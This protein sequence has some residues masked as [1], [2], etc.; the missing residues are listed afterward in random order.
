MMTFGFLFWLF[1]IGIIIACL[2]DLKR[3]EVDN[4]LNL[5]LIMA[6]FS[7]IFFK[8]IFEKDSTIVFQAGLALVILFAIMNLF[9]YGRIFAGGDAKLLFAMTAFFIGTRFMDTLVNIG[10]F[11]LFLMVAGSMY[12]LTYSV[13]LYVKNFKKVNKKIR[14][15]FSA[16]WIRYLILA[17]TVLLV[18]SYV[19]WI[20]LFLAI[21][22]LVLP[23]LYVFAK[24]LE[25]VAMTRTIS[26]ENLRE[27]DWLAKDIKI[28]R[29]VIKANWEGLSLDDIKLLKRK[30][31]V[32][33]KEGL[34]F[35]PAFLIAFI[36]YVF[37]REEFVRFLIGLV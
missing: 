27:G 21:F 13:V 4:W 34:P 30:S 15:G 37:L 14:T 31:K 26:G 23:I 3:R 5:F 32:M 11:L 25:D 24:G 18:F 36:L 16:L 35:V 19:N 22:V 12:G 9:Y 29:K 33:I 17:G 8:A 7:F 1:F 2:Q 20:F 28:G 6:S 10:V